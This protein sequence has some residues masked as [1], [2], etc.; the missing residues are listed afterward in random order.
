MEK[1]FR[2]ELSVLRYQILSSVK[3]VTPS[4]FEALCEEEKIKLYSQI[5]SV[6]YD[7]CNYASSI[8]DIYKLENK[9]L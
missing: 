5:F 4:D 1:N 8:L 9:Y 6:Y 2:E 3:V 7:A